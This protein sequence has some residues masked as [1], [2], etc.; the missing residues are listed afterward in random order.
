MDDLSLSP[1]FFMVRC[2]WTLVPFIRSLVSAGHMVVC[3]TVQ[4]VGDRTRFPV[5]PTGPYIV[6][7]FSS[8]TL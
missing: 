2:S 7:A 1:G 5:P 8:C 6:I 4:I 3:V